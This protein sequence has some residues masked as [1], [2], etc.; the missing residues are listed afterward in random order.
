VL[1]SLSLS[2][3]RLPEP[4]RDRAWWEFYELA[5]DADGHVECGEWVEVY[6]E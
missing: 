5:V 1:D 6:W 2:L 3:S 4:A